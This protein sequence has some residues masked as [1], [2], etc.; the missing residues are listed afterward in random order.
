MEQD[1]DLIAF[2]Y[3]ATKNGDAYDMIQKHPQCRPP[4][5]PSKSPVTP[6]GRTSREST[7]PAEEED[8]N[9]IERLP[10]IEL[11]FS[12][13]PRTSSGLV[14]G[15]DPTTSDVLLPRTPGL[16]RRH[17]ALTYKNSFKDRCYRLVVRDL[18][19]TQGTVVT[20][21]DKGNESRSNFDW[22]VDGFDI[23]HK[24]RALIVQPHRDL[25]FQLVIN[26]H[27]LSSPA[28]IDNVAR[29]CH[30]AAGAE[31]LLGG[32]GLQNG[33]ETERNSGILT[34][35]KNPIMIS[36]G[37]ISNGTF[38]IVSHE[39]NVSTG[40]EYACKQPVGVRYDKRAWERE[41]DMMKQISHDN[42][43]RLCFWKMEPCPFLYLEYM[44][45]GNLEDAHK[46]N[47]FSYDECLVIFHQSLSAVSYLH[48]RPVPIAHR[49]IKPMN[50]LVQSRD[51]GRDPA[52]LKIKLSDFGTSK[53]AAES[54]NTYCGSPC[55]LPPEIDFYVQRYTKAVDIWSLGA[56]IL[57]FAYSLPAPGFGSGH[58]WCEK[59]V[60]EVASWD[61]DGLID[62]LECML[63]IKPEDR[64]SAEVCLAQVSR[65]LAQS[66][67]RSA[68]P[69]P[70]QYS[71]GDAA[72]HHRSRQGTARQGTVIL[73]HEVSSPNM[74]VLP[75]T[76][77]LTMSPP[78][79]P[80]VHRAGP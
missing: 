55:Y 14:F 61:L 24:T 8:E 7:A 37:W 68:T 30:G 2:L 44:P 73:A 79:Y 76:C 21:D 17:F 6:Q 38:G 33:P 16:S 28:Y 41:V 26:R 71:Q 19:S 56:V 74:N 34:P 67:Q 51:P 31:D 53:S 10:H 18:G 75:R 58:A 27:D 69:T 78:A 59:L 39:W 49:D 5:L 20:Y 12:N 45:F 52:Y 57:R 47:P 80:S 35:T 48:G 60:E 3:P 72:A 32:L 50:I 42:I 40:E 70:A 23:A 43:V 1:H 66:R 11:R 63:V 64:Y 9:L 15:T 29:F 25:G 62:I 36:R 22:I 4:K 54:L 77:V 13:T 65:L 46:T